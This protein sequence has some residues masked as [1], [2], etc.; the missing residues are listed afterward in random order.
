MCGFCNKL[1]KEYLCEECKKKILVLEKNNID[2]YEKDFSK[3]L[4]IFEYNGI[5]REKIIDYKFN[6]K[7]YLYKTFQKIILNNKKVCDFINS[8]DIIIPVPIHN[9]RKKERGYN[10]SLLIVKG[11]PKYLL[12]NSNKKIE[13][14]KNIL[15]KAIDTKRQ[16][17]LSK[18]DRKKNVCGAYEINKNENIKGKNILIFDDIFT[19]GNTVEECAKVLKINGAKNIGVLTLAKD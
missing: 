18:N 7:A 10:Q 4:Y 3:H 9:K 15:T 19:T 17:S 6:D 13:L 5:I 14:G 2:V 8:Y 1:N 12:S 16:S 11:L